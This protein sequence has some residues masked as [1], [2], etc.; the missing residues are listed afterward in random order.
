MVFH[1]ILQD[2]LQQFYIS[3]LIFH[4]F[5]LHTK[6]DVAISFSN[7]RIKWSYMMISILMQSYL[8]KCKINHYMRISIS[9][10]SNEGD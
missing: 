4:K 7:V 10:V 5:S 1:V 9:P 3:Y 2:F 6:D 8:N